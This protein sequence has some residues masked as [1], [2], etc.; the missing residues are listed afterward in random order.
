MR[1]P[2]RWHRCERLCVPLGRHVQ[3]LLRL[4]RWNLFTKCTCFTDLDRITGDGACVVRDDF[5]VTIVKGMGVSEVEADFDYSIQGKVFQRRSHQLR[6]SEDFVSCPRHR[7]SSLDW[8]SSAS[9]FEVIAFPF[10]VTSDRLLELDLSAACK[11]R[12]DGIRHAKISR[13]SA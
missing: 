6:V 9:C 4:W 12:F 1:S 8:A 2:V 10:L 11:F 3:K 5:S 13:L 7:R